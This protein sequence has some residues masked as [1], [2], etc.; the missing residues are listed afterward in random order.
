MD[1]CVRL[2]HNRSVNL[3]T[4]LLIIPAITIV[5]ESIGVIVVPVR[6]YAHSILLPTKFE[7]TKTVR[8]EVNT[9]PLTPKLFPTISPPLQNPIVPLS[10]DI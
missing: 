7:V 8:C 2:D 10:N 3:S 1:L 4:A 6:L 5:A 9:L